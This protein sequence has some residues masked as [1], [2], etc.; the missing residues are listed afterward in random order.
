MNTAQQLS[1][2][3]NSR[4]TSVLSAFEYGEAANSIK[5]AYND[6][7]AYSKVKP[8]NLLDKEREVLSKAN[9]LNKSYQ[10]EHPE[11]ENAVHPDVQNAIDKEQKY[12]HERARKDSL[13]NINVSIGS[14]KFKQRNE[15]NEEQYIGSSLASKTKVDILANSNDMSKGNIHIT[16]STVEAPVVNVNASNNLRMDAGTNTI[17]QHDDYTSS[18]W[19]IGATVSPHGSGVIGLDA[20]V[21]KGK[22]NA[23]ETTKTHTGTVILG[24]QVN[25]VSGNNTEI[26][27]SKVIGES[28]TTKVGHDLKIESL[29]DTN[30]YHKI[31]KNKGIS[32]SYGMSGPARVGFDNSRGTTDSHYASVTNQ[33]GI[34]AGDGGYNVQVDNSTTLTG[35][36]IK[37]SLD[38]FK[39]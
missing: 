14:S 16:G 17:V 39:E 23:L 32:V 2:R 13:L 24:K 6:A 38:K 30:D 26:I 3:A 21:Y 9:E 5:H 20:N 7:K 28:V 33:A 34:Y 4:K 22:E 31:S 37:G 8:V 25:T 19:S 15:L 11:I 27:G 10:I 36:I 18:G 29:Q 35:G 12:K 1:K